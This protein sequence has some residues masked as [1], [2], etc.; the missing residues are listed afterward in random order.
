M[1][2]AQH[3]FYSS[4]I[5]H[6][7]VYLQAHAGASPRRNYK[8]RIF[9]TLLSIPPPLGCLLLH[10]G[11]ILALPNTIS[12]PPLPTS[13]LPYAANRQSSVSIRSQPCWS[14]GSVQRA[15]LGSGLPH[16][17]GKPCYW[18]GQQRSSN[19]SSASSQPS[20]YTYPLHHQLYKNPQLQSS[21]QRIVSKKPCSADQAFSRI[22]SVWIAAA[23]SKPCK[24]EVS[25][26]LC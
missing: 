26:Q 20:S 19:R 6:M 25:L 17:C 16:C 4:S 11:K 24:Q 12:L 13:L 7:K 14:Q 18:G 22:P 9:E 23:E 1:K 2:K 15:V 3:S 10:Q 21:L 5:R 8:C